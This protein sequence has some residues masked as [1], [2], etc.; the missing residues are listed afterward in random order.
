MITSING[1]VIRDIRP[2]IEE[3]LEDLG[4]TLGVKFDVGNC[5]F[6]YDTC[7]FQLKMGIVNS[8]GAVATVEASDFKLRAFRYGLKPEDLGRTFVTSLGT[9]YEIIGAKPRSPKYPII[10]KDP[11]TGK[12]YKFPAKVVSRGL[13]AEKD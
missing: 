7:K 5:S 13:I 4:K 9:A 11:L 1:K 8:D 6:S 10:G 2:L 12:T 3:E